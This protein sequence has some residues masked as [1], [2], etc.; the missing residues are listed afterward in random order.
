MGAIRYQPTCPGVTQGE[1]LAI[2]RP[3]R[4][5]FSEY[6]SCSSII[7]ASASCRYYLYYVRKYHVVVPKQKSWLSLTCWTS[8]APIHGEDPSSVRVQ[9]KSFCGQ[10]YSK[11]HVQVDALVVGWMHLFTRLH[12]QLVLTGYVT[13]GETIGLMVLG[14]H[15]V[16]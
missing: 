8:S 2:G 12:T 11:H 16:T 13:P 9:G 3:Q 1:Q 15:G 4:L 7:S 6:I 14:V 5:S 10:Q